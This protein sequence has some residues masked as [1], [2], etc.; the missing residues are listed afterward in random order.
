MKKKMNLQKL[1]LK[2]KTDKDQ[3]VS[4]YNMWGVSLI[5]V[6]INSN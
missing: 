4:I 5:I 3:K 2:R 1:K 6:Y